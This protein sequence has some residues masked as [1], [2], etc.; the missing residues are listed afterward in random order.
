M[1]PEVMAAARTL[2]GSLQWDRDTDSVDGSPTF[3]VLWVRD[4]KYRHK[5]LADVFQE[6]VETKLLPLVR[7]CSK[8]HKSASGELVLCEALVRMYAE[9]QRRV[10]PAHY[11]TDAL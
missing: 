3:E 2:V 7:G 10:H 5:G 1:A 4:D 9:G 8:L 6:T 11:D